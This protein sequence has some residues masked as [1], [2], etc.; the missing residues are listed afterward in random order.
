LNTSFGSASKVDSCR[1]TPVLPAIVRDQLSL[2][3]SSPELLS[4]SSLAAI[5]FLFLAFDF[6]LDFDFEI[7]A[8]KDLFI[9][10]RL[11]GASLSSESDL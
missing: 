4:E 8:S 2:K 10:V 7:V 9:N 3:T 1:E 5:I 6:G 11:V